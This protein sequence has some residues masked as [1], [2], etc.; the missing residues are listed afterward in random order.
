[1]IESKMRTANHHQLARDLIGSSEFKDKD[2]MRTL[3]GAPPVPSSA[4]I[5]PA[6]PEAKITLKIS[7]LPQACFIN[8]QAKQTNGEVVV[9][10]RDQRFLNRLRVLFHGGADPKSITGI[11]IEFESIPDEVEVHVSNSNQRVLF[12]QNCRGKW[13]FRMWGESVARIGKNTTSNGTEVFLCEGGTLEV[14]EDCM[15]ATTHIHVGDSHS[16]FDVATGETLNYSPAPRI[17]I[18]NHVWLASRTTV[19]ADSTI[20]AGSIV[21][22]GSVAKGG[23]EPASLIVGMP[24]KTKRTG[25][26]WTRSADGAGLEHVTN[27]LRGIL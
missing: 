27:M 10:A 14:G 2:R 3:F 5:R 6:A 1:M 22:V 13:I 24:A 23:F 20:G 26:S 21:G 19:L 9:F 15:F 7:E 8:E 25:V 17:A 18:G 11:R 16:I 4:P 12:G